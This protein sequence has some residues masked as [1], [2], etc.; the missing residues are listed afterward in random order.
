MD[1]HDATPRENLLE[2]VTLKLVV[3]SATTDHDG[4]DIE[5]VECVG[6]TMEQHAVVRDHLGSLVELTSA[7]LWVTTAK[8]SRW[9]DGLNTD[10]PKHGLRRES[11]L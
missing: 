7:P 3:A 1:V 8:I 4:F 10:M 6:D 9:Q 2:L 11:Y 5:I